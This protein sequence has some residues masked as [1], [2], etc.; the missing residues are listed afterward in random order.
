MPEPSNSAKLEGLAKAFEREVVRA[1]YARQRDTLFREGQRGKTRF[2]QT[3]DGK[4]R[5]GGRR[6]GGAFSVYTAGSDLD[7]LKLGVF[8]RWKAAAVYEHGG[9]IKPRGRYLAVPVAPWLLTPTGRVKKRY[10][11]PQTGKFAAELLAELVPVKTRRGVLLVGKATGKSRSRRGYRPVGL[12]SSPANEAWEPVILLIRS[13]RRN[14]VLGFHAFWQER[15]V[16][17]RRV[18][19][20][21]AAA[22]RG[23]LE[24]GGLK[25]A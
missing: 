25:P 14:A 20:D 1:V 9:V 11:D 4:F 3:L 19:A 2:R 6:V 17:L 12:S 5:S 15:G 8:T 10:R 21:A 18:L 13:T 7:S 24:R 22:A 16:D 23:A